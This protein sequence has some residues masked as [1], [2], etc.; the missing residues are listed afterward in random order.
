M[1]YDETYKKLE[2][3]ADEICSNFK[4]REKVFLFGAGVL[5]RECCVTLKEYGCFA[6]FIDN[7]KKNV[8]Y[9]CGEDSVISFEEYLENNEHGLILVTASQKNT[10]VIIRQLIKAG[11]REQKDFYGYKDFKDYVFP[12]V[13][14]YLYGR[15]FMS[16][17]QI[18][19][20]ER[21]TLKCQKCAHGCFNVKN[22][23]IDMSL[24]EAK[25]SVDTFFLYIDY[26]QEFVLIGGEPLLYKNLG[27]IIEYIGERYR[28]K[29]GI[30]SITSNGTIMPDNNI[31]KMCKKYNVLYRISNYSKQVT[32]LEQRYKELTELLMREKILYVLGNP[33][34][35][36]M[37][38]GF[39][40]LDRDAE[41]EELI[42][43]FDDCKTPCREIRGN[44]LYYCVMARSIS[45]NL[46]YNI[47]E[48]DYLDLGQL[49]S[50][51]GRKKILEFNLGYSEKG[52]LDMCNHCY[53]KEAYL[54]PVPAA[55][56]VKRE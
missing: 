53:G 17:A 35:T 20:T 55:I 41:E 18:S 16:L 8:K 3:Y 15:N 10:P 21:C 2:L 5:G 54:H 11:L 33:E 12:I 56:Q 37:D 48:N 38:Y 43:V 29:I 47:G 22:D 39:D 1:K 45:E 14:Y 23:A 46:G 34:D 36:W 49:D 52:Y 50:I 40:Y 24:E 28:K 25:K 9:G 31:I 51:N 27:E 30:F 26:I 32:Y 4:Q 13:S 44:K 42:S 7:N 19:L 6:G